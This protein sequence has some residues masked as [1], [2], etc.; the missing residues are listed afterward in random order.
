MRIVLWNGVGAV[1][2]GAGSRE[3]V[4]WCESGLFRDQEGAEG[5]VWDCGCERGDRR[6]DNF[7]PTIFSM[8]QHI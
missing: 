1:M 8:Q 2:Q 5:Y 6:D 7:K 3:F 4:Y